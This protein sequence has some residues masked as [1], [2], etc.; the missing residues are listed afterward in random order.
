MSTAHVPITFVPVRC[1]VARRLAVGLLVPGFR[2]RHPDL[3][4]HVLPTVAA[5]DKT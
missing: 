1:G 5:G 3:R 4:R 2:A